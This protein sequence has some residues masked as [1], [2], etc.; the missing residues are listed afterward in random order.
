[1]SASLGRALKKVGSDLEE[2]VCTASPITR[3]L[4]QATSRPST[5]APQVSRPRISGVLRELLDK[6]LFGQ[7]RPYPVTIERLVIH[8]VAHSGQTIPGRSCSPHILRAL[9]APCAGIRS[10]AACVVL[11]VVATQVPPFAGGSV[12]PLAPLSVGCSC[13]SEGL[14]NAVPVNGLPQMGHP[15]WFQRRTS[16]LPGGPANR[17]HGRGTGHMLNVC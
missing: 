8:G 12:P 16:S 11:A 1:M 7:G 10:E 17:N 4:T 9:G 3:Q 2:L 6:A 5:K 13:L 14:A 15:Q